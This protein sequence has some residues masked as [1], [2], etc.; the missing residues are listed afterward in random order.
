MTDKNTSTPASSLPDVAD[1][2]GKPPKRKKNRDLRKPL[3]IMAWTVGAILFLCIA[4]ITAAY[5]Y[6]TPSRLS[7]IID[8]EVSKNLDAQLSTGKVSCSFIRSFP[9]ITIRIDSLSLRSHSLRGYKTPP[10]VTDPSQ[11]LTASSLTIKANIAHLLKGDL[12]IQKITVDSLNLQVI[13]LNDSVNNYSILPPG[14]DLKN[15]PQVSVEK[16]SIHN[17]ARI[18]FIDFPNG[19]DASARLSN[20]S[21]QKIAGGFDRY[22]TKINGD[23]SLTLNGKPAVYNFPMSLFGDVDVNFNPLSVSLSEFQTN[24]DEVRGLLSLTAQ[25]GDI[26]VISRATYQVMNIRPRNILKYIIPSEKWRETLSKMGLLVNLS[27]RLTEPWTA[28]KGSLPTFR[29]DL[30]I[31][32]A[33]IF[34]PDE[35]SH[36]R[37]KTY[38]VRPMLMFDGEN[39]AASYIDVPK[40]YILGDKVTFDATAHIS[41]IMSTPKISCQVNAMTKLENFKEYIPQLRKLKIAGGVKGATTLNFSV[42]PRGGVLFNAPVPVEMELLGLS[43][44][45]PD[46]TQILLSR[47]ALSGTIDLGKI[48]DIPSSAAAIKLI[49]YLQPKGELT[50]SNLCVSSPRFRNKAIVQNAKIKGNQNS[51]TINNL[52]VQTAESALSLRGKLSGLSGFVP[53]KRG[54]LSV[55]LTASCDTLQLNNLARAYSLGTDRHGHSNAS[56]FSTAADK[57]RPSDTIPMRIPANISASISAD[58]RMV[59]YMNLRLENMHTNIRMQNGVLDLD[60]LSLGS[61]FG[62][63]GLSLSFN[64]AN[65]HNFIVDGNLSLRNFNVQRFFDNF[66]NLLLMMPEA[67][68]ISGVIGTDMKFNCMVFPNMY[69]NIPSVWSNIHL[70]ADELTLRQSPLIHRIAKMILIH[71]DEPLHI[72]DI[73]LNARILDNVLEVYPFIFRCNRYMLQLAG[74]N[75]FNGDLYYHVGVDKSP[76]PFRFGVNVTGLWHKPHLDFGEASFS[77]KK[78]RMVTT[79]TMSPR[80]LNLRQELRATLNEALRKASQ[81][82]ADTISL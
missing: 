79:T 15:L 12:N 82:H 48:N 55:N 42:T 26:P 31:P 9:N 16:I 2:N 52:R 22:Q 36:D 24:F 56:H 57:P 64:T 5:F 78:S 19:V 35:I 14:K 23:L 67:G 54:H 32:Y 17:P 62:R 13:S 70:N 34:V 44:S 39:P 51:L 6:L 71:T 59:R 73:N 10:V 69:L 41:D 30:E 18:R 38:N 47:G 28:T 72:A 74:L 63:A 37:A 81:L 3:K 25:I 11:L 46:S 27:A 58:A 40:F 21:I 76:V 43:A 50:I 45:T 65:P 20:S 49:S 77:E 29:A 7:S 33:E 8:H 68:N 60:T 61:D 53:G 75:N 4:V 1:I 66:H 80:T